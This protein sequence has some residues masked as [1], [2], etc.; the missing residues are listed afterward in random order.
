M[1]RTLARRMVTHWGMSERLGPVTFRDSEEHP[2][3]GAR[4]PSRGVSAS[5]RP[6]SS[7][8]RCRGFSAP[9]PTVPWRCSRSI[10]SKL[11]CLA[12]A[13]EAEET[14]DDV[15]IEK[16]LGPPAWKTAEA[17]SNNGKA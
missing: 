3:L 6:S 11:E 9:P 2:F 17:V 15:A 4:L 13:L 8:R 5:T 7:T 16:L 1:P 10:A 14:L 12:K